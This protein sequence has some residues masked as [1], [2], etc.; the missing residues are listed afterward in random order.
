MGDGDTLPS[1]RVH[2]HFPL[3][4]SAHYASLGAYLYALLANFSAHQTMHPGVYWLLPQYPIRITC[5]SVGVIL[6]RFDWVP[7]SKIYL[8]GIN[9]PCWFAYLDLLLTIILVESIVSAIGI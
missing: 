9:G 3:Y 5:I 2:V 1:C 4:S 8:R 6:T 7:V